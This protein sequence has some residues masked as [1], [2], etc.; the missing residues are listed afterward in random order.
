MDPKYDRTSDRKAFDEAKS[1]V[2]G[3]VDAGV[4]K[5]PRIFIHEQHMLQCDKSGVSCDPNVSIPVIDLEGI[6]TAAS[7]RANIVN[8]V[9]VACEKWGFFQV[10]NHGIEVAVLDEMIDGVR[11]FHEQDTGVKKGFYTRD[12]TKRVTYNTNFDFYQAKA[13]NR[14]DT[15]YCAMAPSPPDPEELPE[16]C[17]DIMIDFSKKVM[18]LGLTVFEL[19]SEALGLK[20]NHLKDMGCGEGLYVLGHYFPEC[21][22]PDLTLGLSRHTDSAFLTV[23][24][25]D[26]MGGL[27]VLHENRWVNVLPIPGSL[28]I[29]LG[30]MMRLISNDKFKSV[31]HRVIAQNV[32]PRISFFRTHSDQETTPRL[33]GPIKELLSE[34][35]P[36]IYRGTTLKDYVAYIYSKGLDGN[37]GLERFKLGNLRK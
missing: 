9:R 13:A 23:V 37:S 28:I 12:E 29:N 24:L 27:E 31:F 30:D 26:Q 4:T 16:V 21:P 34:V 19:L 20:P 1:G 5:I 8:R 14:R 10:V 3:L 6:H 33:S 22:E 32:G 35:N 2:K 17:S 18:R 25:Q 7:V 36:P 11:R 15:I